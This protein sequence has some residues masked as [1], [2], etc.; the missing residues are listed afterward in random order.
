MPLATLLAGVQLAVPQSFGKTSHFHHLVL[1][2]AILAA[3]DFD[4]APAEGVDGLGSPPPPPLQGIRALVAQA[5]V[6]PALWKLRQSGLFG[7]SQ[8]L[9]LHCLHKQAERPAT[10]GGGRPWARDRLVSWLLAE[11]QLPR[12]MLQLAA[13]LVLGLELAFLPVATLC[14]GLPRLWLLFITVV[15]HEAARLLLGIDFRHIYPCL[16]ALLDDESVTAVVAAAMPAEW[17]R[18]WW[19]CDEH[20]GAAWSVTPSALVS[21]MAIALQAI[22]GAIGLEN[23]WPCACYPR[24]ATP[25]AK[26]VLLVLRAETSE[27]APRHLTPT[28]SARPRGLERAEPPTAPCAVCR[29]PFEPAEPLL[30]RMLFQLGKQPSEG[31]ERGCHMWAH[32][33]ARKLARGSL[34]ERFTRMRGLRAALVESSSLRANDSLELTMCSRPSGAFGVCEVCEPHASTHCRRAPCPLCCVP[35]AVCEP[36]A[37]AID[38][39]ACWGGRAARHA[40]VSTIAKK[41]W[42][43]GCLLAIQLRHSS[44]VSLAPLRLCGVRLDFAQP[45]VMEGYGVLNGAGCLEQQDAG[46]LA[47]TSWRAI[48]VKRISF[49]DASPVVVTAKV[50]PACLPTTVIVDETHL[51]T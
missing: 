7:W 38:A 23:C 43:S 50:T 26:N 25:P 40:T 42:K 14:G 41:T 44:A 35:C 51:F 36:H 4:G 8:S 45:V 28:A 22:T 27:G 3:H 31:W 16:L 33:V 47:S 39:L 1:V 46:D 19:Q 34:R 37:F 18:L 15:F 24:F 29:V 32:T 17:G 48:V 30:A 9:R 11:R 10:E 49:D 13:V 6:W 2:A 20:G 12:T 21:A 5:Y